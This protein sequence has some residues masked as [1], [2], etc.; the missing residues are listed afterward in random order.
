MELENEAVISQDGKAREKWGKEQCRRIRGSEP[1]DRGG[2][3]ICKLSIWERDF[4]SSRVVIDLRENSSEQRRNKVRQ[5]VH[6][7]TNAESVI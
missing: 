2:Q 1:A 3:L 7:Q 4:W 5:T 6:L